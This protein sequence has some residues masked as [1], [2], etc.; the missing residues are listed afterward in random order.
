MTSV[1]EGGNVWL[2]DTAGMGPTQRQLL[3]LEVAKPAV[4]LRVLQ[5]P[6]ADGSDENNDSDDD[7]SMDEESRW[8]AGA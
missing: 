2:V 5:K 6:C 3:G 4:W 1:F 7:S 8:G